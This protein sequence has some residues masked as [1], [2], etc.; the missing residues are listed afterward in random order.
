MT[1]KWLTQNEKKIYAILTL[2]FLLVGILA[3]VNTFQLAKQQRCNVET[4]GVL[5]SW[6]ETRAS[7]DS[8]MNQRDSANVVVIE[9]FIDGERPT[10]EE[11]KTWR[12]SVVTERDVRIEAEESRIP[13]PDC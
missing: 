1:E 13:I 2:A 6:L 4:I 5:K 3:T 7:R 10:P 11:L 9:R 8:S 12:D